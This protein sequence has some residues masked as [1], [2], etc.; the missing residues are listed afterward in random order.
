[1]E[2][3]TRNVKSIGEEKTSA[4]TKIETTL[5]IQKKGSWYIASC[6]ELDFV[7][8]GTTPEEARR[9]LLEVIDIQ[10]ED[11]CHSGVL[12]YYL[13]ECGFERQGE[14]FVLL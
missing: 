10:F 2:R 4:T 9:N 7:T 8:Q 1:M 13:A 11:M 6:P 14:T 3:A 12:E 5:E